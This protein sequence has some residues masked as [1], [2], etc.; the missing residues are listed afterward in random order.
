MV[1]DHGRGQDP[2]RDVAPVKK[3]KKINVYM[4]NVQSFSVCLSHFVSCKQ[5]NKN[6]TD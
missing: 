3:K 1:V 5:H 2:H 4:Y 6:K